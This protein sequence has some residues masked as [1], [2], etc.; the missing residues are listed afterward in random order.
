MTTLVRLARDFAA[1]A[2]AHQEPPCAA[3]NGAPW[4]TWLLLSG[5]GAGKTR[6][7]AEFVRALVHGHGPF[8]DAPHGSLALVGETAHDVREVMIE[9]P[10]GILRTSPR[11][12]RPHWTG[13]RRRLQWP[14][15]A[16]AYAFSAEDPEQLRG[17]QFDGAWCDEL[18]KWHHVEATFDM[19]Q[20]GLRLSACTRA[21]ITTTPRPIPLIKRLVADARNAVTR[22]PT[23]ANAAYLSPGF[24]DEVLA[25]YGGTRLGRQEIDGEII[26]ERADALWSRSGIEAVRVDQAPQLARIV[27]GVD[28]PGSARP[29]SDGCG[30]VAAGLSENGVVY[31]LEDASVKGMSPSGWA[32]KAIALYRRLAA[33]ALVAEVNLGATWCAPCCSRST[34]AWRS[35][36]CTPRAA[37]GCAPNRSPPCTSKAR[38]SM[39]IRR[40]RRWKMKCA[41]LGSMVC[42]RAL[43]PTGSTRW[44]GR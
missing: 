9:G 42:R 12:E 29:G 31:V 32:S 15:G 20:F 37:S 23:R 18:A 10:S 26:E 2:H 39:S 3:A 4:R 41:T 36:P 34:P 38:S 21:L 16:V 13:M 5:R 35:S 19:L 43:R 30:I 7:G 44:S 28:P 24:V 27:V 1:L 14:N 17:P 25:R 11:S 33:D 8:A 40:W 22:A 6:T